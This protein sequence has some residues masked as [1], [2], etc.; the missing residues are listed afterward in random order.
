M[1]ERMRFVIQLNDGESMPARSAS[2]LL[3]ENAL[4]SEAGFFAWRCIMNS[5]ISGQRGVTLLL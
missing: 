1:D 5:S 3:L 4:E 2:R